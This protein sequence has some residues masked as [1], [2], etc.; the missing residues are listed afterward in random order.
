[1]RGESSREIRRRAPSYF[2][3]MPYL[4][5][6][7]LAAH[8]FSVTSDSHP[9]KT[10]VQTRYPSASPKRDLQQAIRKMGYGKDRDCFHVPQLWMLVVDSSESFTRHLASSRL[11]HSEIILT[12]NRLTT[13]DI[14]EQGNIMINPK[15]PSMKSGETHFIHVSDEHSRTWLLPLS[16]CQS[17][18][19]SCSLAILQL[20]LSFLISILSPISGS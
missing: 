14:S 9:M 2:C 7:P 12:C 20:P 17:W 6:E 11:K 19:V 10:L 13:L 5:L 18:L 15:Q 4:S 8:Q 16:K 1:M 3:C